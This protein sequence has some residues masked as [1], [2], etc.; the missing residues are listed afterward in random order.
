MRQRLPTLIAPSILP[1]RHNCT[2]VLTGTFKSAA[3][4]SGVSTSPA[5]S[6]WLG[7]A[8]YVSPSSLSTSAGVGRAPSGSRGEVSGATV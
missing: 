5:A 3:A 8:I 1:S 6:G 7:S 4:S 2:T